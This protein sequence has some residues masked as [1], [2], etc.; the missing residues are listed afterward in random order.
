[1]LSSVWSRPPLRLFAPGN[2]REGGSPVGPIPSFLP[3]ARS[4]AFSPPKDA[5]PAAGEHADAVLASLEYAP[6]EV[7]RLH[8]EE[9]V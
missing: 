1:M 8:A 6:D 5:V 4:N 3:P 7:A 9:V 2:W